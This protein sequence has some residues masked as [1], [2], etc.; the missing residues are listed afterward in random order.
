MTHPLTQ[1]LLNLMG[2]HDNIEPEFEQWRKECEQVL[3]TMPKAQ[4]R[5]TIEEL[6]TILAANRALFIEESQT[7]FDTLV[8]TP[9]SPRKQAQAKRYRSV[10]DL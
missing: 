7:I 9:P 8:Q 2:R 10:R 6:Q 4:R 3:E 5:K 1:K